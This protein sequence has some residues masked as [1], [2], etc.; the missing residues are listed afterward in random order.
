MFLPDTDAV[1]LD[2][3]STTESD[4]EERANRRSAEV[5]MRENLEA[6]L[7]SCFD[8]FLTLLLKLPTTPRRTRIA[9]EF[10]E[11]LFR[12]NDYLS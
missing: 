10:V 1:V 2:I 5:I 8:H 9:T 12:F 3:S 7:R 11:Q 4:M 6:E